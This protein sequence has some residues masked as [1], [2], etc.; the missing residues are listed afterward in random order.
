[1]GRGVYE[2]HCV[3]RPRKGTRS[4]Y[5]SLGVFVSH[6]CRAHVMLEDISRPHWTTAS[7]CDGRCPTLEPSGALSCPAERLVLLL[8][9][10]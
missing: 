9:D 2:H 3:D 5:T 7:C 1:M 6:V 10:A 4:S 8:C